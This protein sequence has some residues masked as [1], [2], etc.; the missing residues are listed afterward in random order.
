[1]DKSRDMYDYK[2]IIGL[3]SLT[4]VGLAEAKISD[5]R[6]DRVLANSMS[7]TETSLFGV[8]RQCINNEISLNE[9]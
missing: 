8:L 7:G 4:Q 9:T 3:I 1:M 2:Y 5:L 6:H